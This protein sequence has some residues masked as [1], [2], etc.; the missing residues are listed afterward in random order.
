MDII[1]SKGEPI[2]LY[3]DGYKDRL[4]EALLLLKESHVVSDS[5]ETAHQKCGNIKDANTN[6]FIDGEQVLTY[7]VS[8]G[9]NKEIELVIMPLKLSGKRK[10][11]QIGRKDMKVSLSG[12]AV[13]EGENNC[14]LLTICKYL[15]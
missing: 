7:F 3:S 15:S 12:Y 6:F 9:D 8:S 5:L 2:I 10:S 1:P 14:V 11:L 13:V 4:S